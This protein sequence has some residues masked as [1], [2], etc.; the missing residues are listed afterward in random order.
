M[1]SCQKGFIALYFTLLVVLVLSGVGVS[2]FVLISAQQNIIQNTKTSLQAY[3]GAEAGVEDALF[4][5]K[6][7]LQWSSPIALGILVSNT[8]I[9]TTIEGIGSVKTITATGEDA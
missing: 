8:N 5:V 6:N 2:A 1:I 9:A 7:S 4:R 3:Y